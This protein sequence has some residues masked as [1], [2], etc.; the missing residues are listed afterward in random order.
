MPP[1]ATT[2]D[3]FIN[4]WHRH[5]SSHLSHALVTPVSTLAPMP[6]IFHETQ[7]HLTT[8]CHQLPVGSNALR[9]KAKFCR[10]SYRVPHSLA[11]AYPLVSSPTALLFLCTPT[12]WQTLFLATLTNADVLPALPPRHS[13]SLYSVLFSSCTCHCLKFLFIHLLIFFLCLPQE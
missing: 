1:N 3:P 12:T 7:S 13:L 9:V 2:S 6:F 4:H 11:P 8:P 10:A 5:S